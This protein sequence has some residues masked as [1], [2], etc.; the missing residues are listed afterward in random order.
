M[1]SVL[2][3]IKLLKACWG[4][5]MGGGVARTSRPHHRGADER[6]PT[7]DGS[8]GSDDVPGVHDEAFAKNDARLSEEPDC[9]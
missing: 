1:Q 6:D 4:D 3:P 8:G 5:R 2:V 9:K 7:L